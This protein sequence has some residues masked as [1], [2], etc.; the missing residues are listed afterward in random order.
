MHRFVA[1]TMLVVACTLALADEQPAIYNF[2]LDEPTT[3]S[4]IRHLILRGDSRVAL[5]R[6]YGELTEE[7]KDIVR[8]RYETIA[9]GD[10][11]PYPV[12][13]LLPIYQAIAQASR[14]LG[15]GV[16]GGT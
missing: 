13:G 4:N 16:S 6:S 2:K 7:E 5:N 11:P 3:G 9:P 10:E 1:A 12:D 8:S 14:S 15:G